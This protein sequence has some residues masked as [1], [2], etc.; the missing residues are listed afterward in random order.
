MARYRNTLTDIEAFKWTGG[1]DQTE[2]PMWIIR[3]IECGM[4]WFENTGTENVHMAIETLDGVKI[5]NPGDYVIQDIQGEIF[6]CR[7]DI[8]EKKYEPVGVI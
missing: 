4:V 5:A 6:P 1:P 3:A 2:D 7:P 8:F